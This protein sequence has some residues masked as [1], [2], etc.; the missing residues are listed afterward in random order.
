MD[1]TEIERIAN[2]VVLAILTEDI[3]YTGVSDREDCYDIPKTDLT[4]IHDR[5]I[6]VLGKVAENFRAE[7]GDTD[8]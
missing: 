6:K 7:I 8:A 4:A 5:A 1:S 2:A 3:E